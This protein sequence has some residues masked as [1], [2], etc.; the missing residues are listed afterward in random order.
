MAYDL[1]IERLISLSPAECFALWSDPTSLAKWWGPKDS[2]GTPF[3]SEI[4]AWSLT[5]GTKWAIK[6]IAP[7]GAEFL[8]GGEMIE[9]EP[10]HLLRFSFHWI[11]ND[12]PGPKTEISVYFD[13]DG[14]KTRMTFVQKGFDDAATRD[15]HLEGWEECV[16]R[17]VDA[18]R[19]SGS[20]EA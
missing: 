19:T 1:T 5:T 15:D 18:V 3:L 6:M 10:P 14:D 12:Q 9:V 8:Q 17:F 4:Q 11:E 7:D 13:S 16:D 2:A 20:G